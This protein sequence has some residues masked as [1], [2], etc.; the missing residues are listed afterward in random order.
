MFH[1][2]PHSLH[3]VGHLD[4]LHGR[5]LCWSHQEVLQTVWP[6]C[7]APHFQ[8]DVRARQE[9]LERCRR[10]GQEASDKA[11]GASANHHF[12]PSQPWEWC[13]NYLCEDYGFWKE[14]L[15]D[16]CSFVINRIRSLDS[17][18]DDDVIIGQM[19]FG[20]SSHW[21]PA[22]RPAT[23]VQP[24]SKKQRQHGDTKQHNFGADGHMLTNRR[25]VPLCSGF[26]TGSCLQAD[27]WNKCMVDPSKKTPVRQVPANQ[28]WQGCMQERAGQ[29]YPHRM[30]Q[31]W[32]IWQRA[33]QRQGEGQVLIGC[34][35]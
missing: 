3:P 34:L 19:P 29:R 13:F 15:E 5:P 26:Q 32:Q 9:H 23:G 2:L 30:Q 7:L 21:E 35:P 16:P 24:P 1:Y 20:S 31:W 25:G 14:R 18:V 33:Q 4:T 8:G 6:E 27:R 12:D 22:R 17:L 28:S 10:I 11:H